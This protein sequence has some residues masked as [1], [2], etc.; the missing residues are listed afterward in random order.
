MLFCLGVDSKAGENSRPPK[1]VLVFLLCNF[2]SRSVQALGMLA[3][4]VRG[5]KIIL[6]SVINYVIKNYSLAHIQVSHRSIMCIYR[7]TK[8]APMTQ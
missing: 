8:N 1:Q 3:L 4:E 2:Q 6:D 7:D 5:I